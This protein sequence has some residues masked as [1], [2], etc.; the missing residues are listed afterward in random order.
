MIFN[1][2]RFV[3]KDTIIKQEEF[4]HTYTRNITF[5]DN[6]TKTLYQLWGMNSRKDTIFEK[7]LNNFK[8]EKN[9]KPLLLIFKNDC[10]K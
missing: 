5:L 8:L 4:P 9:T 3:E 7:N 2:K 1:L 6:Q 10:K